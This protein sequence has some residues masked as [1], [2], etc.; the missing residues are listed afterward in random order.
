[1]GWCGLSAPAFLACP[2]VF[3]IQE[4]TLPN[5][6]PAT[7][8]ELMACADVK[9][10]C[11]ALAGR[12]EKIG[13][14]PNPAFQ[15]PLKVWLV[16]EM[17][18]TDLRTMTTTMANTYRHLIVPMVFLALLVLPD[19]TQAREGLASYYGRQHTAN[20]EMS[21]AYTVAHRTLPFGT[22]QVQRDAQQPPPSCCTDCESHSLVIRS[23]ILQRNDPQDCARGRVG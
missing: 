2:V 15:D 8:S 19:M 13:A 11:A 10:R 9:Q 18:A 17:A 5:Q 1:L 20:G 3:E 12:F 14:D 22:R 7:Q 6:H 4:P 16:L 23:E 21:S